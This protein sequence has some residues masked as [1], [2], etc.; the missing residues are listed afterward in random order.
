[1]LIVFNQDFDTAAEHVKN[2]VKKPSDDELLQ[3]YGL[4]KQ[5]TVGDVNTGKNIDI[6]LIFDVV[7]SYYCVPV[8]FY[9]I[10]EKP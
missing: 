10:N 9:S 5:G 4:F 3:I 7:S 1:M 2:L 8:P 6:C